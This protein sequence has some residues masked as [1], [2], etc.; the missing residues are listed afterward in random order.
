MWLTTGQK[1]PSVLLPQDLF[2]VWN[3]ASLWSSLYMK[4]TPTPGRPPEQKTEHPKV[5]CVYYYNDDAYAFQ[6]SPT[7][8]KADIIVNIEGAPVQVC[9][10]SGA[11]AS[12]IDYEI[13]EAISAVKALP[14]LSQQM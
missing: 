12:T 9:I 2:P 5:K 1:L 11:T 14:F 3:P 8:T 13:Y 4:R 7:Q 6:V 10:D